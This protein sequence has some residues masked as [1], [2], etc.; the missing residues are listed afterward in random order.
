VR[1]VRLHRPTA[2]V[3]LFAAAAT[4]AVLALPQ[5]RFAYDAPSLRVALETAAAVIALVVAYLVLGRFLRGRRLDA[6][7]L[8]YALGVLALSN[9]FLAV[10]LAV[11]PAGGGRVLAASASL[12]GALILPAAAFAPHRPLARPRRAALG[13]GLGVLVLFAALT[14][15]LA[16]VV[17]FFPLGEAALDAES[18]RPQVGSRGV[19]GLQLAGLAAFALAAVGFARRAL[20][21][22]DRF[23][24]LV[25]AGTTLA[26][27][28]LLHYMLFQPLNASWVYTGDVLRL[29]F[30]AV[31]LAAAAREIGEYWRGLA[32]NAVLEE[33]RRLARELHDG[34][35]Q[36][37]AFIG[38]RARRLA[39]RTDADEARQ[40]TAAAD[41]ALGD[42][43]RAIAALTRPLD[44]PLSEVLTEAVGQV[45]A[46][47]PVELDLDLSRNVRVDGDAREALVRIACEAVS[48]AARHGRA[49]VVRVEL[50]QG[51]HVSFRIVDDGVGFEPA[52]TPAGRF[53]LIS[54]RERAEAV[55]GSFRVSSA[56]GAG[57]AVEVVLP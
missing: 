7:L 31:L 27:F 41:R 56:P 51:E 23:I 24:G 8:A 26:A 25:A 10:L 22:G 13:L 37:L 16:A 4:V 40:I 29:L 17:H 35:A 3:A 43:R 6:L 57:T 32:A 50:E 21:E 42:S 46:R 5:L 18:S 1:P 54:M 44:Q 30:H 20:A 38:R 9:L 45:V 14:G 12:A 33:R 2:V 34:V 28:A 11:G 52:A 47:H 49:H 19:L 39:S 36:E 48:N 55:G 15:A 53:G